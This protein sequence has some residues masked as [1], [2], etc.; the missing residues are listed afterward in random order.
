MYTQFK[1]WC[2]STSKFS[3]F[4]HSTTLYQLRTLQ[5]IALS[6]SVAMNDELT[7]SVRGCLHVGLLLPRFTFRNW[8]K[9]QI[10]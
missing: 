6:E 4:F 10:N 2:N 8:V 7:K 3:S 9:L 5:P 1:Q